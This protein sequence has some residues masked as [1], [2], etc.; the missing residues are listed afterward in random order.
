M[1]VSLL[2]RAGVLDRPAIERTV[3]QVA[4][5]QRPDGSI[6]WFHG[7]KTDPWDHVESAMALTVSGPNTP[8]ADHAVSNLPWMAPTS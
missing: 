2:A 3:R 5:L 8:A 6:P 7:D 1:S 4:A